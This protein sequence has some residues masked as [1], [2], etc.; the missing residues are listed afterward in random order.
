MG[1]IIRLN[2]PEIEMAEDFLVQVRLGNIT[3]GVVC[4]RNKNGDTR[5][6]LYSPDHATYIIGL[7][8]RAKI[9]I[10]MGGG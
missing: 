1:K 7:M 2:Q 9:A 4:F 8:E 6:Q 10:H 3:Q 5:Y